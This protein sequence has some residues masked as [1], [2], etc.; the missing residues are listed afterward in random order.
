VDDQYSPPVQ[1]EGKLVLH[2]VIREAKMLQGGRMTG[3]VK[4]RRSAQPW[5]ERPVRAVR[6]GR[7]QGR[8]IGLS[9]RMQKPRSSNLKRTL[10]WALASLR[11]NK[12]F[13]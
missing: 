8:K 13:H 3:L 6:V 10:E 9:L 7:Q 1:N 12:H 2:I 5:S 4:L 11:R